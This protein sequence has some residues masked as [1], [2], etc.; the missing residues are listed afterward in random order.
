VLSSAGLSKYGIE[1]RPWQETV[2]DYL[3]LRAAKE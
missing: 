3:F 2:S 1:M